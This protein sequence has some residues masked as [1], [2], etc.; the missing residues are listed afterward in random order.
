[1]RVPYSQVFQVNPDGSVSPRVAVHIN[2]VQ[3]GPGV[4]FGGGV[5]FGGVDLAALKGKDLDVEVSGGI[6]HIKGHY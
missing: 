2:G 6:Y 5:S 3:M 4:A 1:M